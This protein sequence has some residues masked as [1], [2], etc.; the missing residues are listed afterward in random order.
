MSNFHLVKSVLIL[1][2]GRQLVCVVAAL[3]KFVVYVKTSHRVVTGLSEVTTDLI[4]FTTFCY[5]TSITLR[6]NA[7]EERR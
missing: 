2:L 7:S 6:E 3:L 1:N 5:A 4:E